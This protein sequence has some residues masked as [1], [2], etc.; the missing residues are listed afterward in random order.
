M[1]EYHDKKTIAPNYNQ[2]FAF[3]QDL[4]FFSF[5]FAYWVILYNILSSADFFQIQL[6]QK[7]LSGISSET[8]SLSNSFDH[9]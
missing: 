5:N 8:K 4:S 9:D 1:G 2:S 6:F 7:T 3:L